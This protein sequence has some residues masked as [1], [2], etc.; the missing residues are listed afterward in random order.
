MQITI[1]K[2]MTYS[3]RPSQDSCNVQRPKGRNAPPQKRVLKKIKPTKGIRTV[4]TWPIIHSTE[5]AWWESSMKNKNK[6]KPEPERTRQD[7]LQC[8]RPRHPPQNSERN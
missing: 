7:W 3:H 6:K 1:L 4:C 5:E 8:L 2:D